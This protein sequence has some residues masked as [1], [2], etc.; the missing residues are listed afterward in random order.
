MEKHALCRTILRGFYI[1][2]TSR[3]A[4]QRIH[5]LVTQTLECSENS[6]TVMFLCQ[7]TFHVHLGNTGQ[8]KTGKFTM[9]MTEDV[10]EVAAVGLSS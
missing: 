1:T 6:F 7:I 10:L 3:R 9:V 5:I 8:L 4:E 2:L